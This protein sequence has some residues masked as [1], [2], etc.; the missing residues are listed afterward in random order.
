M[1]F[2]I[3]TIAPTV[4]DGAHSAGDVV[5]NLTE[6]K[7]PSR[8]CKIINCF[9]EV[10]AG[11]GEDTTKIGLLFFQKNTTAALGTLNDS[12]DISAANF[13]ANQYIGSAFLGLS[14]QSNAS[15]DL[16]VIDNTALYYSIGPF[17]DTSPAAAGEGAPG[18]PVVLKGDAASSSIFVGGVVHEG[19]PDLDGTD[20]V[21]IHIHVEY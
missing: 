18:S 7:I 9:M 6:F 13:K 17:G 4:S 5:F 2:D 8:A 16:D 19:A 21:K 11:G 10:S 15:I 1:A 12:A 20:N 3:I 14:G